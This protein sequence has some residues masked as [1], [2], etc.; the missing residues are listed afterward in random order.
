MT[1]DLIVL[2]IEPSKALSVFTTEGAID[3]L[4]EYVRREIDAFTPDLSTAK[5][6]KEI[7]SMARRVSESKVYLESVGKRLADE[8]KE[9]PKKIDAARKVIRDTLD[10]WRDEVRA[11]LTE[12]ED[13]EDARV[14][15]HEETISHITFWGI[16]G[17]NSAAM[18][19]QQLARIEAVA[20]GPECEEFE[21]AY[22]RAKE[23]ARASILKSIGDAERREAE[24]IE[25]SRLRKEADDRAERDRIAAIERAAADKARAQ[26]EAESAAKEREA[27]EREA[28]IVREA[29]EARQR[30][31]SEVARR[32]REASM[33]AERARLDAERRELELTREKEAA[34][35]RAA[36]TE[37]RV[38]REAADAKAREEEETSQREADKAHKATINKAAMNALIKGGL[39]EANAKLA[40]VL[41]ASRQVPAV[42]ISY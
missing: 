2:E 1:T 28:R 12:W 31:A 4:L 9:I 7:A 24:A 23:N 32:E 22:A 3:P 42:T 33:A 35:R 20:I 10:K 11:P 25:L 40:I 14:K 8:Q 34:E 21:A 37:A 36:E 27:K 6:R 26:A 15:A 19:R 13:A 17:E 41:I 18:M 30:E 38:K 16:G 5:S 29:E 39:T